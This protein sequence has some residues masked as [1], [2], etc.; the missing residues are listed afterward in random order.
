MSGCSLSVLRF[1]SDG[2]GPV[3]FL[4]RLVEVRGE[5]VNLCEIVRRSIEPFNRQSRSPFLEQ[6]SFPCRSPHPMSSGNMIGR[7]MTSSFSIEDGEDD[8]KSAELVFVSDPSKEKFKKFSDVQLDDEIKKFEDLAN[9]VFCKKLNLKDGG[10]KIRRQL[11]RL[12]EEKAARVQPQ[13]SVVRF[14]I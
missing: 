5:Y 8:E 7:N 2:S 13:C 10:D 6:L 1:S 11:Q 3:E 4:S 14:L 12:L 9:S